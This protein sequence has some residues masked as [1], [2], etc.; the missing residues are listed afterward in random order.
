M[1]LSPGSKSSATSRR[2]N[3]SPE[4]QTKERTVIKKLRQ[5][6]EMTR[7]EEKK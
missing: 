7:R 2:K 5:I 1:N 4:S 3:R 6:Q